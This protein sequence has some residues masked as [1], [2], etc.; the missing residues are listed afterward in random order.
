MTSEYERTFSVSVP[1]DRAW[2]AFTEPEELEAWLSNGFEVNAEERAAVG[3]GPGGPVHFEI[4]EAREHSKLHYRQWAASPDAGAEVTVVFESLDN[5]TRITMTH[6]GFGG[7]SLLTSDEV[8]GGMDESLADLV[9][10]LEHG[11]RIP[12]HRDLGSKAS[13]DI[14]LSQRFEGVAVRTVHPGGFGD[15]VGL[16]PGDILFQLGRAAVFSI[17]E[18][19]FFMRE[20]DIGDEIEITWLRGG[21]MMHGKERLTPRDTL[22]FAH[23]A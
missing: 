2:R 10:Y 13:M 22:V 8:R 7:E 19:K 20:H 6:A 3:N 12:R 21:D 14:D 17:G 23:R 15:A 5:G 16:Q 9:M 1:V 11:V 4:I 18:V